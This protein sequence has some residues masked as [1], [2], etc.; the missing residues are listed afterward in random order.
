VT[1][2]TSTDFTDDS[3]ASPA[4]W[5]FTCD[6]GTKT[7]ETTTSTESTDAG[8]TFEGVSFPF[9]C[10]QSV[11][12]P[13]GYHN[14]GANS[15]GQAPASDQASFSLN[16]G[17][18]VMTPNQ[19]TFTVDK[20]FTNDATSETVNIVLTCT[21]GVV[22]TDES[23]GYGGTPDNT[24]DADEATD[25]LFY[26]EYFDSTGESCSA[27]EVPPVAGHLVDDSACQDLALANSVPI[28][29]TITNNDT[30]VFQVRKVWQ[31][32]DGRQVVITMT[33]NPGAIVTVLDPTAGQFDPADFVIQN[34]QDCTASENTPAGYTSN[35]LDC[36]NFDATKGECTI[37]NRQGAEFPTFTP[38]PSGSTSSPP[39]TPTTP[40]GPTPTPR[41]TRTPKPAGGTSVTAP[42]A[43]GGVF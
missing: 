33:C 1:I 13:A 29:C 12:P 38:V 21:G 14:I 9:I 24:D 26:V 37:I 27:A 7:G 42:Q 25:A 16:C 17:P 36:Q 19:V 35:Q 34:G 23:G 28:A 5:T 10:G 32:L 8:V 18:A 31:P 6:S 11:T 40:P 2:T 41:P 20:D 39:A 3:E 30:V 4:T 43:L 15:C 22:T